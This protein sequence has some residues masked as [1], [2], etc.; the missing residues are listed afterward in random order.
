MPNRVCVGRNL[1]LKL[2]LAHFKAKNLAA[3]ESIIVKWLKTGKLRRTY[4]ELY[5]P[6]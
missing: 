5:V 2:D 4:I 1:Q 3:S 6:P